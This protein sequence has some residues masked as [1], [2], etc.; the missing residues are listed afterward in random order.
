M[1]GLLLER[2]DK[3]WVNIAGA[4][5]VKIGLIPMRRQCS[6][7]GDYDGMVQFSLIKESPSESRFSIVPP[8]CSVIIRHS[9]TEHLQP[10]FYKK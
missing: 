5:Q 8:E 7:F 2:L 3:T 10:N 1:N 6:V 9:Q 4:E